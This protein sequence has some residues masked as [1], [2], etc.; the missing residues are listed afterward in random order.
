VC[1]C[2][3]ANKW[4]RGTAY[5]ILALMKKVLFKTTIPE[6]F[7]QRITFKGP[8]KNDNRVIGKYG[9]L[10][11][12]APSRVLLESWATQIKRQ[13]R[14]RSNLSVRNIISFIVG[15][16]LEPLGLSVEAW[17][18][19]VVDVVEERLADDSVIEAICQGKYFDRKLRWLQIF[20][21]FIVKS[22]HI[23]SSPLKLRIAACLQT[24]TTTTRKVGWTMVPT[25][26]ASHQPTWMLFTRQVPK[27]Q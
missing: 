8:S 23:I 27:I 10:P 1:K 26:I 4:S 21:T 15:S 6:S 19:D 22:S 13:T 5:K 18:V 20:L 14:C 11:P 9:K 16:S 3:A 24:R 25:C 17:P 12:D 2:I 7:V